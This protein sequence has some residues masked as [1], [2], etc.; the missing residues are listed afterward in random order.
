MPPIK[1]CFLQKTAYPMRKLVK[2]KKKSEITFSEP[3][4]NQKFAAI[5]GA[6]IKKKKKA[7]FQY[8]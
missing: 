6:F 1:S 3:R 8:E 4:I 5:W 2:K 7:E